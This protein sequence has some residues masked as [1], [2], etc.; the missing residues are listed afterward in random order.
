[1]PPFQSVVRDDQAT[2]IVGEISNEGP[3][4]VQPW[5]LDSSGSGESNL[6][7][8]VYTKISDGKVTVGGSGAFIGIMVQPKEHALQGAA[9]GTLAATLELQDEDNGDFLDMGIMFVNLTEAG[10]VG[11]VLNYNT[12]TGV[13]GVGAA[14][15]GELAI[16]NAKIYKE[17]IPGAGLAMIQLTN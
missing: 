4:R 17:D 1:M 9:A 16:P 11:D 12:T 15:G 3:Q 8:L 13:I 6:I 5:I 7:G 10:N 2:G 14:G